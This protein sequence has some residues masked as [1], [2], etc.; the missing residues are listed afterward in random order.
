MTA[1]RGTD[2]VENHDAYIA[3]S[4]R[5]Y[6]IITMAI[7]SVA[8]LISMS[9]DCLGIV[10]ELN[11]I[12]AAVPLAYVLPALCY[13]KLEEGPLLS[14]KKLPALGLLMAGIFAAVSGLLL[15]I[16]NN[17]SSASCA[18]G[19]VMAYCQPSNLSLS[20][21]SSSSFGPTSMSTPLTSLLHRQLLH[22]QL[23]HRQLLPRRRPPRY[24]WRIRLSTR[25]RAPSRP[26]AKY[27]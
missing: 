24:P 14:P 1:I 21:A 18:H 22:R 8:Y 9:T 20:N 19:G 25:P 15:L 7:I 26:S 11:G 6:L 17:T 5:K 13:L 23:L 2:E 3:G 4:D 16:F 10:L 12:L 27:S